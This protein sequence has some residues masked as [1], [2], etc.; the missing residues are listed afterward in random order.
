[1]TYDEL[2]EYYNFY[3]NVM[4]TLFHNFKSLYESVTELENPV[5]WKHYAKVNQKFAQKIVEVK[6]TAK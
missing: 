6:G 2:I 1:M 3:E 5:H 4:K